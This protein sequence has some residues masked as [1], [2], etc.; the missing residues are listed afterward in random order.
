MGYLEVQGFRTPGLL[1]SKVQRKGTATRSFVKSP[2]EKTVL[3]KPHTQDESK[4]AVLWLH[5]G[6]CQNCGPF[7]GPCIIRHLVFRGPQNRIIVCDNHPNSFNAEVQLALRCWESAK[8]V[9]A[10]IYGQLCQVKLEVDEKL[11]GV[12]C[13]CVQT[14]RSMR[15][16]GQARWGC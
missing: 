5:M 12:D 16:Q 4:I 13:A 9:C 7:L 1:V 3:G 6:G 2:P 14:R 11:Y 10:S 8:R 15:S